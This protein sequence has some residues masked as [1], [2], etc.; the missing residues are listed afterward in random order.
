MSNVKRRPLLPRLG[1]M[2]LRPSEPIALC[3]PG[4]APTGSST[5]ARPEVSPDSPNLEI[6]AIDRLG[7]AH[8]GTH[9]ALLLSNL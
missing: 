7:S 8:F 4:F 3:V 5:T 1:G 9:P 6:N 2:S